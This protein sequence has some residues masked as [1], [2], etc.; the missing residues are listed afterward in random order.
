MAREYNMLMPLLL[1]IIIN[2]IIIIITLPKQRINLSNDTC[3]GVLM[4]NW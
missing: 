4:Y 1:I 2:N 3:F